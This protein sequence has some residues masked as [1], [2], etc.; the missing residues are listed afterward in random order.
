ML[1]KGLPAQSRIRKAIQLSVLAFFFVL[2][3]INI[4]AGHVQTHGLDLTPYGRADLPYAHNPY[5]EVVHDLAV[6]QRIKAQFVPPAIGGIWTTEIRGVSLS[7][8]LAVVDATAASLQVYGPLLLT[9]ILPIVFTLLLGRVFCGWICPGYLLFEVGGWLRSGLEKIGIR[10]FD[11][12][13]SRWVKYAVLAAGVLGAAAW[14]VALFAWIYPPAMATIAINQHVMHG[15]VS[16]A[17]IVLLVILLVEVVFARRVWCRSLCPG[18]AVYSV[19]G[20]R[21]VLRVTREAEGC[22][23]CRECNDV[24]PYALDPMRTPPGGEC[25]NCGDCIKVCADGTL[26]YTLAWPWKK[27]PRTYRCEV[28]R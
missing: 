16:T 14:G 5:V 23:W 25:D 11:V 27:T 4:Y 8:P 10:F 15:V 13:V 6:A 24:C 19:L 26:R 3:A 7:D 17:L 18:G 12:Q 2:P 1:R 20:A 9:A 21:R 28:K 22:S